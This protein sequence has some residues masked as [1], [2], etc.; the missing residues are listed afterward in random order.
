MIQGRGRQPTHLPAQRRGATVGWKGRREMS[1][2]S[3]WQCHNRECRLVQLFVC[4]FLFESGR[5]TTGSAVVWGMS[6]LSPLHSLTSSSSPC[7]DASCETQRSWALGEPIP[8]TDYAPKRYP[9]KP[10]AMHM[11]RSD[12]Q[13]H[14]YANKAKTERCHCMPRSES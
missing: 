3:I 14:F 8:S 4:C 9:W 12:E 1:G 13:R 6:N 2:L 11:P 7:T 5:R 10:P